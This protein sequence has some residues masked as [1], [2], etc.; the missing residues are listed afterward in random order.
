[1]A[2]QAVQT[3]TRTTMREMIHSNDVGRHVTVN[4]QRLKQ[5][6]FVTRTRQV[7]EEAAVAA[8]AAAEAGTKEETVMASTQEAGVAAEKAAAE[9]GT[10]EET[11]MAST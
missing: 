6:H 4:T 9:A 8:K 1:M 7:R 2:Q 3:V 10:K 11:V 5:K